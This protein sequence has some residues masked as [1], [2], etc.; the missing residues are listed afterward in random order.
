[1]PAVSVEERLVALEA[2]LDGIIALMIEHDLVAEHEISQA[3]RDRARWIRQK[4]GTK[5]VEGAAVM[6]ERMASKD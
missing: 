3:L 2:A 4:T 1:M 6:L 5:R